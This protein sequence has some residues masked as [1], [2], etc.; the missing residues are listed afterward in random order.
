[1]ENFD[2]ESNPETKFQKIFNL[3][4]E[5]NIW[6]ENNSESGGG[7]DVSY[8]LTTYIPFVKKL[9]VE[10]KINSV[11]DLGCGDFICGPYIY[12]ELDIKYFGY[13]TCNKIIEYNK[14]RYNNDKYNFTHLDIFNNWK[15]IEPADIC[16]IK[17][18][19]QH[20]KIS[21][22][23]HFLDNIAS[24]KKYK[25]ILICNCCN[26]ERDNMDTYYTGGFRQLS[27]H[28]FPLK[29]YDAEILYTYNTKEISLITCIGKS[30][31]H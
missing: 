3:I 8:N 27:A 9:I 1:M 15:N 28:Y 12:D 22:I 5:N 31:S 11:V 25:Y 13:D 21:D 6:L 16:I 7:S 19:L 30:I 29:R 10:K 2:I 23:Y 17:D 20:W 24:S 26:Q 14:R 4:Y 18:V